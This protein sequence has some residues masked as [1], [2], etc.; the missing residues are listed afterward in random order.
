MLA[1][2][3]METVIVGIVFLKKCKVLRKGLKS[4]GHSWNDIVKKNS[5]TTK[6]QVTLGGVGKGGKSFEC[7]G[8]LANVCMNSLG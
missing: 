3:K 2:L 1:H 5:P 4:I 7:V 8:A 6:T